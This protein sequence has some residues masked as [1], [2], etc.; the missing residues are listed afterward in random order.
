MSERSGRAAIRM[1]GLAAVLAAVTSGCVSLQAN[2]PITSVAEGDSGSSQVQIWPSPPTA[3][4]LPTAI[5]TGFLEAARSGAA[6]LS[7][8]DAYL[9]ADMR[10]QWQAEQNTVIVLADDSETYPQPAGQDA[11]DSATSQAIPEA[12]QGAHVVQDAGTT[13]SGTEITEQVQGD[14]LGTV[15]SSGLYA[16]ASGPETY[17]FGVTDT[18][19]GYRI[20]SLPPSFGVLMERSDFESSYNRHDVYY[21][22]AAQNSGKLIPTQIY[23]PAIDTDQDLANAMAR[24]IV[25][26]VPEQ[27]GA[28]VQNSVQ[29][30]TLKGGG[31]QFQSD[32][33]ATITVDSHGACAKSAAAC[34]ELSQQLEATLNSL[35]TKVT[36]VT[37]TDQADNASYT[38]Q[39][40]PGLTAY[41]LNQGSRSGQQFDAIADDGAVESVTTFG[42]VSSSELS[43]GPAKTRFRQVAV[44]PVEPG[45]SQQIALVSQDGTK[46]YIPHKQDGAYEL[47]QVYPGTNGAGGGSVGSLSWDAYGDL[48]F[49]V[50]QGGATN[51]YRYG[52]DSLSLVAVGGFGGR[53]T[54][55][56]A[57]PDG[58]RVA[59]AYK[60]S[61]GDSW[62]EIAA[63]VAGPDG[64]WQLVPNPSEVVAADWSQVTGFDWYNEDSLAVLGIQ[65]NS[66]ILGL[67]QVYADGSSVYDSLTEQ[68][69]EAGPP[70]DATSFVWSAG[71]L[72]IAAA[73]ANGK[74]SLYQL[75]VEGQDAQLLS[76][77]SGISPSY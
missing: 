61:T 2:G 5:V 36:S 51:V 65:P 72:P 34:Q 23:L 16:A 64:G 37:V 67:Y 55:V 11:A 42:S 59:V 57:A 56:S 25:A 7:I 63:A 54:Q 76:G 46:V 12:G 31:V 70:A 3:S 62:V 38:A 8:A 45:R 41:G 29:G 44:D 30:A 39:P 73:V 50:T 4:E 14:L 77:V 20:S 27:L 49:T 68:P 1:A 13:V 52:Q 26:G 35:S 28:A 74:N 47:G 10:A 9:T 53:V 58:S 48:W 60:D 66:Q 6:N 15:D 32:G 21:E 40:D 24:V 69:V 19:D 33:S 18:K 43:Y 71:G 75:S 22:N 17:D